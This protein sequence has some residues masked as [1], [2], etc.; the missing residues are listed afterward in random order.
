MSVVT[1]QPEMLTS[2]PPT[3]NGWS[4]AGGS[5]AHRSDGAG[6]DGSRRIERRRNGSSGD[7]PMDLLTRGYGAGRHH[8]VRWRIWSWSCAMVRVVFA[9]TRCTDLKASFL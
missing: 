3:S 8:F 6:V 1:T 4:L 2:E 9:G 7:S 5:H